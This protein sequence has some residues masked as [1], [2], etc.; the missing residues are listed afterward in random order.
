M[1]GRLLSSGG[2]LPVQLVLLGLRDRQSAVWVH[3]TAAVDIVH[4]TATV[5][6]VHGTSA[7]ATVHGNTAGLDF[8]VQLGTRL[9]GGG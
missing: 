9:G 5:G 2:L 8:T 4:G 6:I 3:G 7:K 1:F